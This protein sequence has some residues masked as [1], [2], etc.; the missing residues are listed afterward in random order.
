MLDLDLFKIKP[1]NSLVGKIFTKIKVSRGG[2]DED[3]ILFETQ[4]CIIYIMCHEQTC[5]ESVDIDDICGDVDCLL[6]NPILIAEERVSENVVYPFQ[7]ERKYYDS[8]TWT[9]YE[10]ATIQGSVS[11]RW[12]GSSNGYYSESVTLYLSE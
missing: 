5:C 8:W 2:V 11:I 1:F 7:P 12:F 6:G 9:F 4:D 3:H 10:L